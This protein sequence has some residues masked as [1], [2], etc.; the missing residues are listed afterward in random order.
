[1]I[2]WGSKGREKTVESG[3]FFCPH[4]MKKAS[5]ARRKVARY[6][7]LYF[8]PL[9]P[10]EQLGEYVHCGACQSEYDPKI[11]QMSEDEIR[12]ALEP[13]KC[14]QC[15]NLNASGTDACLSCGI[16]KPVAA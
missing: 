7:T 12:S 10:I 14:T 13:W 3:E 1:M 8:I 6:F 5:Y 4:C 9:F 11:L 16:A 15:E 2:I